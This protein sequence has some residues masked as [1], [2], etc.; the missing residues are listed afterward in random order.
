MVNAHT[1]QGKQI[2][3]GEVV[4]LQPVGITSN[5]TAA[6]HAGGVGYRGNQ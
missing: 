3:Q 4:E 6:L 5:A 2:V 1:K